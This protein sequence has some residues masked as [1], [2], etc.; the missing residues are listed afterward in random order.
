MPGSS[1][2]P[3]DSEER[4]GIRFE[5][6]RVYGYSG[7]EGAARQTLSPGDR[8]DPGLAAHA[9]VKLTQALSRQQ[10]AQQ[11]RTGIYGSRNFIIFG[12]M[13]VHDPV[14][15]LI[16]QA[17]CSG[18]L[19]RKLLG[20]HK[21]SDQHAER[22]VWTR[23]RYSDF[24]RKLAGR[25]LHLRG[26]KHQAYARRTAGFAENFFDFLLCICEPGIRCRLFM[27]AFSR[28]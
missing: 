23:N 2:H 14:P 7:G 22:H 11:A 27:I 12:V 19:T 17:E 5:K 6:K 24:R 10:N 26:E 28:H 9:K 20:F 1:W 18:V 13:A 8:V 4:T 3:A 25:S 16:K 15:H 21:L